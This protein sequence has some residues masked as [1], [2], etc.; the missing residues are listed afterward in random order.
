MALRATSPAVEGIRY[1]MSG[2]L[3]EF[4]S[5]GPPRP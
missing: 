1:A 5:F 3:T 2:S 4:G